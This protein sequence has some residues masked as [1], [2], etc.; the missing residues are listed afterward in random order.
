MTTWLRKNAVALI[1][2]LV[3]APT[4]I[5]VAVANDWGTYLSRTPSQPVEVGDGHSTRFAGTDWRVEGVTTYTETSEEGLSADLPSGT[6]LVAVTVRVVPDT[7][8]EN[9]K[10]PGCIVRLGEYRGASSAE[11]RSWSAEGF[12]PLGW[13]YRDDT[14]SYCVSDPEPEDLYSPYSFTSYFVVP[15][16]ASD[17]LGLQLQVTDELPRYLLFRL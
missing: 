1:A 8:D 13:E 14:E 12:S 9:G 2:V 16:D 4:T 11:I 15:A 10:Q 7:L 17:N 5:G 3:L 6:K